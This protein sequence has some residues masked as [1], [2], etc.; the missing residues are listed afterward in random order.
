MNEWSNAK[1]KQLAAAEDAIKEEK[2]LRKSAKEEKRTKEAAEAAT[3]AS[4]I[5]VTGRQNPFIITRQG[6]T[7]TYLSLLKFADVKHPYIH[8]NPRL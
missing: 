5:S 4:K 8:K 7:S 2:E 3:T 6:N 1:E